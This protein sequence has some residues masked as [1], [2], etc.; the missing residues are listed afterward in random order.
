MASR[1]ATTHSQ[2]EDREPD[3]VLESDDA[4]VLETA[5]LETA[6]PA[7]PKAA[8]PP[9]PPAGTSKFPWQPTSK[10]L[11][12]PMAS[13]LRRAAEAAAKA[14]SAHEGPI[15]GAGYVSAEDRLQASSG[16][17]AGAAS[18][19][20]PAKEKPQPVA[21]APEPVASR[22][23]FHETETSA[24]KREPLP[25]FSP[26][27]AEEVAPPTFFPGAYDAD[28]AEGGSKTKALIIVAAVILLACSAAFLSWRNMN[29]KNSPQ[30]SN[31]QSAPT[32]AGAAPS[33]NDGKTS[34]SPA[35]AGAPEVSEI[36]IAGNPGTVTAPTPKPSATKPAA[37]K[38]P[39]ENDSEPEVKQTL[40]V[41]NDTRR[42]TQPA[43]PPQDQE[44]VPA[45][46]LNMNA[47]PDAKALA[48]LSAPT[49]TLPKPAQVVRVSQGVME[50]L[51]LKRVNP[52]YPAQAMQMR[53]QG[54]VQLQ[55]TI[56]KEGNITNLKVVSGDGILSRTAQ[57]A[58]KQWKYKPYY[59][60]GEPVEIQTQILVNFKLPN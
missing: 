59:L 39:A 22:P 47:A 11:A 3:A 12:E 42:L 29:G 7:P 34:E 30:T 25:H 23:A 46:S 28:E 49:P 5:V 54:T 10:P 18:A 16:M 13:A 8:T 50:G 32:S 38:A 45:P 56:S 33:S 6:P 36:S 31:S 52:H 17:S 35:P 53:I 40:I 26:K 15:M 9:P 20:A 58:V 24:P 51:L 19:P 14:E 43:T 57:E 27:E 48:G 41:K 21:V 4:E 44:S 1:P 2:F 37:S 55:A 60:N